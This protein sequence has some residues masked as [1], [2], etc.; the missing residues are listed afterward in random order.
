VI[1]ADIDPMTLCINPDDIK[2]RITPK[3]K[4]IMVVHYLGYPP[5]FP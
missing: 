5:G 3:T 2:H 1:F 4:V